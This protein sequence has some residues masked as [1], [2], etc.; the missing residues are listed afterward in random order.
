VGGDAVAYTGPEADRISVDLAALLDDPQRR[1]Q[2]GQAGLARAKEF[3][4]ASSAEAHVASW[5]RAVK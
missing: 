1:M 4:W 2:L 3:S 5:C